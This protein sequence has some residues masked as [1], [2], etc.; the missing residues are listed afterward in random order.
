[1]RDLSSDILWVEKY[2]PQKVSDT[3]LPES[4]K[5]TFQEIV[6]SGDVLNMLFSG[7]SGLGKTTVAKAICSELGIDYMMVNGS[8]EGRLIETLRQPITKFASTVS[9][10]GGRKVVI[11]D[12]ADYLNPQTVQP[13][14]RNFIEDFSNNC[15]FI[16]TCNYKHKLIPAIHSR[17]GVY[18]F[19]VTNKELAELSALFMKRLKT[20]L[21]TEGVEYQDQ[22][23]AELIMKYA[24]DWRR[25]LNECQ[26]YS[27]NGAIDTGILVSVNKNGIKELL[28][29][30]REKN[31]KSVRK[32]V[33]DNIHTETQAIYRQIYDE[34]SEYMT[35]M[36]LATTIITMADYQYKDAF[37]ADH[38]INLVAF[39]YD[40]MGFAEWKK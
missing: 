25:V 24:P 21:D 17:C 40:V 8:N 36:S 33:T 1:M 37:V 35:P 23:I 13:A 39:L 15:S 28:G 6:N 4:M 14:L 38:E 31:L 7:T 5:K 32:W 18:D 3:I 10:S 16:L 20:I 11:L 30:M 2:R 19:N 26:R 27:K 12:E 29:F 9:I 34:L 22:V